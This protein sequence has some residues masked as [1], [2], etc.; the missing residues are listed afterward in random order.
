MFKGSIAR[1]TLRTS[2]VLGLR[3]IAQAGTLL[4]VA[5]VLG[6]AGFGI[7]AGIAALA[8]LIGTLSSLGTHLVLLA[9]VSRNPERE[10]EVLRYALPSTLLFSLPLL[11]LYI[12]LAAWIMPAAALSTWV[13]LAIGVSELVLQPLLNMTSVQ[14]LGRERIAFSQLLLVSPLLLRLLAAVALLIL[15]P[16]DTI[17]VYALFY[18]LASV[19][20][21]VLAYSLLPRPWPAPASWRRIRF[22]ELKASIGYAFLNITAAGP[23]ELDKALSIKLL[24]AHAAG[25][26]AAAARVIGAAILPVVALMV[27]VMPRFFRAAGSYEETHKRLVAW[28]FGV[29]LVYG[30]GLAVV[31]GLAADLLDHLYGAQY[32]GVG[33]V[34]RWLCPAIPA[35]A[36]RMAAGNILMSQDR[37][38][39]RVGF[40]II[41]LGTLM[42][43]AIVLAPR[44]GVQGMAFALVT[45][46]MCMAVSGCLFVYTV[47]RRSGPTDAHQK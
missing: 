46:E 12:V 8:V 34:L 16:E 18:V 26:Y 41:G 7:F 35:L 27:S 47:L 38:W 28:V 10:D 31:F 2:A 23:A 40:E 25:L 11:A 45:S 36:L 4:A 3:L 9:E 14:Q 29:S 17:S 1:A 6:P 39:V 33:E 24:S 44:Y 5:R 21:L 30:V 42:L 20:A 43:C 32:R 22:A 37:P 13:L 19:L 15:K